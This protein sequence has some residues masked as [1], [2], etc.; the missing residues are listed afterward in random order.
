MQG[1]RDGGAASGHK[2][3]RPSPLERTG[4]HAETQFSN[5]QELR[6]LI[7]LISCCGRLRPANKNWKEGLLNI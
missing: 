5:S 4:F 3:P 6:K 1:E 2:V 7:K